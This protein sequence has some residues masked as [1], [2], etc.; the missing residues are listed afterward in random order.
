MENKK[1]QI[2]LNDIYKPNVKE[3]FYKQVKPLGQLQNLN[4]KINEVKSIFPYLEENVIKDALQ[5]TNQCTDKAIDLIFNNEITN[6]QINNFEDYNNKYSS[7]VVYSNNNELSEYL[8]KEIKKCNNEKQIEE[9]LLFNLIEDEL[10]NKKKNSVL[11]NK[12]K[13]LTELRKSCSKLFK[14]YLN[15]KHILK[16]N[17][18][19]KER[20]KKLNNDNAILRNEKKQLEML[21]NKLS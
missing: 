16:T 19:Q 13:S 11:D 8:L 21:V 9:L 12:G 2:S 18:E 5:K 7:E 15:N 10:N 3:S 6:N 14:S 17:S 4:E 1:L 20:L